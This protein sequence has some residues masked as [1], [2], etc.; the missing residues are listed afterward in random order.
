MSLL[1]AFTIN[2]A[3]RAF[4]PDH[5]AFHDE[6]SKDMMSSVIPLKAFFERKAL[7]KDT[8]EAVVFSAPYRDLMPYGSGSSLVTLVMVKTGLSFV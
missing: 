7:R 4:A 2:V 1:P 8:E 6:S 3:K 5:R